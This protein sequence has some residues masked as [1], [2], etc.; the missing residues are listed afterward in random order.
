MFTAS[1]I[2]AGDDV[3]DVVKISTKYKQ[4]NDNGEY[5]LIC[6]VDNAN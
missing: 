6:T 1:G 4:G 5:A 2:Y 3:K